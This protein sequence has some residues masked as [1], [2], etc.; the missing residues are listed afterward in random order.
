M[1]ISDRRTRSRR[2]SGELEAV[3]E[4]LQARVE[5]LE[6]TIRGAGAVLGS[7][8][9]AVSDGEQYAGGPVALAGP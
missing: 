3:V 1:R 6:T 9:P 2:R 4:E 7:A 8:G 5:S